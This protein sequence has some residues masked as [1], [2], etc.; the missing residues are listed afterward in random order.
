[1]PPRKSLKSTININE[2]NMGSYE[3]PEIRLIKI[4]IKIAIGLVAF[5]FLLFLIFG[6]LIY[7][8]PAGNVGVYDLFGNV[9]DKEIPTGLHIK[10]PFA[11]IEKM[12]VKTQ[13]YT[14][15][16]LTNEG[17]IKGASDTISALTKEGLSVD[18]DITIWYKLQPDKASDIYQTV[19][20]NYR[21][22]LVRPKI[23]EAIRSITARYEAKTIY[24]EDR[25]TVQLEIQ[26]EIEKDLE[27]RGIIIEKVLLRNVKLP[28][29]LQQ[30]IESKLEA[31][32]QS[33]QM[34]FVLQ[35]E[36][37]EAERK[38]IEANGLAESQAIIDKTLTEEYLTFLWIENL[39]KHSSIIYVPVGNDGIPL[40]KTVQ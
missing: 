9:R 4:I 7:S 28:A 24:S 40:F 22:V 14:M 20:V 15:S 2:Y 26:D 31:E 34:E 21:E 39:D 13:E 8:I 23:R 12:S 3:E 33:Q 10:L 1:M 25:A 19:G 30:A 27:E 17:E 5:V 18:L 36:K 16:I 29:K 11:H 32:Q 35:K 38:I 6:G 37:Q